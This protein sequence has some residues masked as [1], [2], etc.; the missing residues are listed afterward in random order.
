LDETFAQSAIIYYDKKRIGFIKLPTFYADFNRQGGRSSA[1]DVKKEVLKLKESGVDGIII[2]LRQNGGG[3]LDDVVRMGGIFI[4]KGPIVQVKARNMPQQTLEDRQSGILYDGPLAIMVSNNSASASEILAAAMQDYKRAV[5][6]GTKQTFGKGTVQRFFNLDDVTNA[7]ES[8]KP[9]GSI[10]ITMQKFYRI[11]GSSTQLRGVV[12]DIILPDPYSEI[13]LGEAESDAPL[14]YD[15]I[16]PASYTKY[17]TNGIN[18]SKAKTNSQ[19]RINKDDRF[20]L[21]SQQAKQIKA[22]KDDSKVNLNIDK[23]RAEIKLDKESNKKFELLNKSIEGW[24]VSS[25]K[26]DEAQYATDSSKIG[27]VQAWHKNITKDVYIRETIDVLK[28]VK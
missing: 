9:L 28:D 22:Q 3:S 27:R 18:F 10:K 26:E 25:L 1:D 11:N 20:K 7:D 14:A 2:D 13:E 19:S 12:P 23:F 16:A 4:D 15:E 21:I 5:I 24:S 8:L 17:K 6:V